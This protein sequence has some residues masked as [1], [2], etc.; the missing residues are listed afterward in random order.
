MSLIIWLDAWNIIR[1]V[2][3]LETSAVILQGKIQETITEDPRRQ[4]KK[5]APVNY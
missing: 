4:K 3:V 1:Y 2:G 5:S